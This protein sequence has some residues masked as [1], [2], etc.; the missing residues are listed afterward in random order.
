MPNIWPKCD[1]ASARWTPGKR[2]HRKKLSE[3]TVNCWRK[4]DDVSIR[5]Q[6]NADGDPFRFEI[7]GTC[8]TDQRVSSY[9]GQSPAKARFHS[10]PIWRTRP[11]SRENWCLAHHLLG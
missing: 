3:S 9:N 4:A 10:P 5:P 7:F 1:G 2:L 6:R 11:A 8:D